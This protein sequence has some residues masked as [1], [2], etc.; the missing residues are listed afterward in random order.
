MENDK[1]SRQRCS[2]RFAV[3]TSWH[4]R[5]GGGKQRLRPAGRDR[6]FAALPENGTS[7]RARAGGGEPAGL[8]EH[9]LVLLISD[10]VFPTCSI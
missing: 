7:W 9:S 3:L 6:Q 5:S 4:I 10:S 1:K 2:Q 8:F